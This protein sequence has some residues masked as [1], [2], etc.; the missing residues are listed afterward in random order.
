MSFTAPDAH[1]AEDAVI[2]MAATATRYARSL[3]KPS[4][5]PVAAIYDDRIK[6]QA[7]RLLISAVLHL[8]PLDALFERQ[9]LG[10]MSSYDMAGADDEA[11]ADMCETIEDAAR[12]EARECR[13]RLKEPVA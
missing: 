5:G 2:D 6:R 9:I 7:R 8:Y 11:L 4:L 10:G 13:E 12:D 1:T 3:G